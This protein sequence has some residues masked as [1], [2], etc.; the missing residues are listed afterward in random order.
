[1]VKHVF[2]QKLYVIICSEV[3]TWTFD[4]WRVIF[5]IFLCKSPKKPPVGPQKLPSQ[6]FFSHHEITPKDNPNHAITQTAWSPA[7]KRDEPISSNFWWLWWEHIDKIFSKFIVQSS[8]MK[9][10]FERNF[11]NVSSFSLKKGRVKCHFWSTFKYRSLNFVKKTNVYEC[12]W[13]SANK[14]SE[15]C[16]YIY[17]YLRF[18]LMN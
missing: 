8:Q 5:A 12:F 11:W 13:L 10:N 9:Y 1:M 2:E 6:F 15:I 18:R 4:T 7:R 3:R 16:M 17:N 14:F